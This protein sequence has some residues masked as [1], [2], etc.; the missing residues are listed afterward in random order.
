MRRETSLPDSAAS[1]ATA[2][3]L[4]HP[5]APAPAGLRLGAG[6]ARR[7]GGRTFEFLYVL[8][9]SMAGLRIPAGGRV[10][11]SDGLWQHTCLE[12][13]LMPD[14]ADGYLEFNFSPAGAWAAYRFRG[15]RTGMQP[16]AEVADPEI[17]CASARDRL[18]VNVTLD[19]GLLLG[20]TAGTPGRAGLAAVIEDTGG[21][22]SYWALRH[23][24]GAPDFHD[25]ASFALPLPPLLAARDAPP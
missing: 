11:R 1:L 13:F 8:E 25:P 5:D 16:V 15:R 14:G 9:G 20:E 23:G 22:L 12:A 24:A 10:G 19:L 17:R 7:N 21:R 6:L 4:P 3:L 2:D 18:E